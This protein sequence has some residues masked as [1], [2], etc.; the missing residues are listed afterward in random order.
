MPSIIQAWFVITMIALSST[1]EL[2]VNWVSHG[3]QTWF[4]YRFKGHDML[5]PFTAGWQTTDVSPLI[6]ERSE[7]SVM[8]VISMNEKICSFSLWFTLIWIWIPWW[9]RVHMYMTLM[10]GSTL[11]LLPVYGAHPWVPQSAL[12]R[13]LVLHI[14]KSLVS[15][16]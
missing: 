15:V 9:Y 11:I 3:S 2:K 14:S 7:V 4:N 10:E 12:T 6:I 5:A 13:T 1:T 8:C 16:S